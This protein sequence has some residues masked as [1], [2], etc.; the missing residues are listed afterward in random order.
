MQIAGPRAFLHYIASL[1]AAV[2]VY[3]AV[4]MVREPWR[5]EQA[6]VSQVGSES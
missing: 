2:V 6:A 5:D 3:V 4:R 1:S